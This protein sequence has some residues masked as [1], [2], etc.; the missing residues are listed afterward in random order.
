MVHVHSHD[1]QHDVV[2][3]ESESELEEES[4]VVQSIDASHDGVSDE[5]VTVA[6]SDASDQGAN[7]EHH[8]TLGALKKDDPNNDVLEGSSSYEIQTSASNSSGSLLPVYATSM[9]DEVPEESSES[10][11]R[12]DSEKGWIERC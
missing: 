4:I 7:G 6:R 11:F 3:D 8:D 2:A 5:S 12:S 9:P 10:P 1:H